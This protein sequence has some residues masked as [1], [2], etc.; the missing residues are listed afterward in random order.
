MKM[1]KQDLI[2]QIINKIN[3]CLKKNKKAIGLMKDELG[4]K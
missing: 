1:L 2:L 4:Q 3:R